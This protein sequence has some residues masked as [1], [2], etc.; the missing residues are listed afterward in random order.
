MNLLI[1][2]WLLLANLICATEEDSSIISA[3]KNIVLPYIKLEK[4]LHLNQ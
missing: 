2:T 4:W 1:R 3:K